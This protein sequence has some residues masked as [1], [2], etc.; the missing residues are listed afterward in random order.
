MIILIARDDYE[1][2]GID[3]ILQN[4]QVK[5]PS[6]FLNKDG[7]IISIIR[8]VY[9]IQQVTYIEEYKNVY[10]SFTDS[11]INTLLL[12]YYPHDDYIS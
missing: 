6:L 7:S 5:F 3:Y 2:S 11:S 12:T 1:K 4:L 8:H 9:P 10:S